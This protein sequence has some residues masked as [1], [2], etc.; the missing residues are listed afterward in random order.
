MGISVAKGSNIRVSYNNLSG[1]NGYGIYAVGTEAS[2]KICRI[3]G[4]TVSGFMKDGILASGLAAGSRI[5]H[6]RVSTGAANGI[7]VKCI[8]KSVV[9][10]NY[11]FKNKAR[12]ILLQRCE[13]AM[14]ADNFVSENAINGIELNIRSNHSSVQGNV[15][16][17]NK[18]SGLRIAGSKGISADGNSFRSNR[19]YAAEFIRSH[20]SS[21][22]GNRF[23]KNGYSNR[24]HV[25]NSKIPKK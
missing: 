10:G 13:S 5:E 1:G 20:I 7:L 2:Q 19:G 18:K 22:K 3:Y 17:S 12:G 11:S 16:G 6:N 9:D 25:R 24:I 8:D 23:E 21:Y 4:N 15:C 14:V